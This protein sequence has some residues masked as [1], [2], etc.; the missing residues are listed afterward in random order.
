MISRFFY[1]L[2][3]DIDFIPRRNFHNTTKKYGDVTKCF[4]RNFYFRKIFKKLSNLLPEL[5]PIVRSIRIRLFY[6]QKAPESTIVDTYLKFNKKKYTIDYGC[7]T[8]DAIILKQN[9]KVTMAMDVGLFKGLSCGMCILENIVQLQPKILKCD[10]NINIEI[11][12]HKSQKR[13]TLCFPLPVS[14]KKHGIMRRGIGDNWF[15]FSVALED[16]ENDSVSIIISASFSKDTFT[17]FGKNND[18]AGGFNCT[19]VPCI[20]V[21]IP[22]L[23]KKQNDKKILLISGES[24]TDPFWMDK[25]YANKASFPN[26][27]NLSR[28]STRYDRSYSIADSTLPSI[29]SFFTGMYPSQHSF[30]DYS[31]PIYKENPGS[32][33]CFL[34][35]SLRD[36]GY[37][38]VCQTSYPRFDIMHGWGEGFDRYFQAELPWSFNAPDASKVTRVF[39]GL[40]D[41]NMFMF[42]HLTRLHGPF[43]SSDVLQNPQENKAEELDKAKDGDFLPMYLSQIKIFDEQIGIIV[44]YLKRTDQYKN[45]MIILTGDHGVSM[46]PKWKRLSSVKYA[47][48]EEHSRTPLIVKDPDWFQRESNIERN[49]VSAQ[50]EIFELIFN[51]NKISLPSYFNKLPQY[52]KEFLGFAISETVYHPKKDN[53]AITL[54]SDKFKY[55]MFAKVNWDNLKI[56]NILDE[57]LFSID[58]ANGIV[59]E[60]INML[61]AEPNIGI[62]LKNKAID[63]FNISSTYRASNPNIKYPY[64][65]NEKNV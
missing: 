35:K 59:N 2:L 60:S 49:P 27:N 9:E 13:K 37:T 46:P 65:V 29:M 51:A 25:V 30:G 26:I 14:S 19:L 55:W 52:R 6:L 31:M 61:E 48:Y 41:Q 17:M 20:A 22:T 8:R 63:F 45:T 4:F 7:E 32:N 47:H 43:L 62:E 5:H 42:L 57:K 21:S 3:V 18:T 16:F 34:A 12:S 44:D 54:I 40:R 24:L 33:V 36:A 23:T 11:F 39:E 28:D 58:K 64:T 38:T 15:D 50:K 10:V 1:R 56:I 53:Y